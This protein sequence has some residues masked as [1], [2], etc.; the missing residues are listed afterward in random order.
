MNV[1]QLKKA[2]ENV[3]D[4]AYVLHCVIRYEGQ[5]LI[6]GDSDDDEDEEDDEEDDP[7]LWI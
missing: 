4:D 5:T 1:L 7:D 2:L 3:P 6:L